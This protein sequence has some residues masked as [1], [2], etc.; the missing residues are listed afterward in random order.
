MAGV[1]Y[2]L[3][4]SLSLSSQDLSEIDG[5][6]K[7]GNTVKIQLN[8]VWRVDHD[9]DG[10]RWAGELITITRITTDAIMTEITVTASTGQA[11]IHG[12][13]LPCFCTQMGPQ[14]TSP[15]P[16]YVNYV[17]APG[18]GHW[19]KL[20][21]DKPKSVKKWVSTNGRDWCDYSKMEDGDP[22]ES[23]PHHKEQANRP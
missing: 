6:D 1:G 8:T 3:P 13:G 19:F 23:Y 11:S 2:G 10:T 4:G 17:P 5:Y 21:G 16:N 9:M 20:D 12:N 15:V 7:C 18:A 14:A 22:F